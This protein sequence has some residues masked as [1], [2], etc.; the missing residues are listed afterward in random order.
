M[1]QC[2]NL[3]SNKSDIAKIKFFEKAIKENKIDGS[4]TYNGYQYVL[5]CVAE[6]KCWQCDFEEHCYFGVRKLSK[7]Q[8]FMLA[9]KFSEIKKVNAPDIKFGTVVKL[10]TRLL[11]IKP[12]KSQWLRV[13]YGKCLSE[14]QI[15]QIRNKLYEENSENEDLTIN[16][17]DL[18]ATNNRV[19]T[20]IITGINLPFG[21][22]FEEY[23]SPRNVFVGSSQ[24]CVHFVNK[25]KLI[26]STQGKDFE[27]YFIWTEPEIIEVLSPD[28]SQ[29]YLEKDNDFYSNLTGIN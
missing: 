29:K 6:N 10:Q 22:Y 5:N 14:K 26:L 18:I 8:F 11:K 28:E 2:L 25:P 7:D 27:D 24:R 1:K 17:E 12:D 20:G 13:M 9:D 15:Q 3:S 16:Y 21:Y 23:S 4:F 19:L